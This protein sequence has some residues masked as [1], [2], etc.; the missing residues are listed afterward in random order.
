[1]KKLSIILTA[2]IFLTAC[3]AQEKQEDVFMQIASSQEYALYK[4]A[5]NANAGLIAQNQVDLNGIKLVLDAHLSVGGL[6]A[7]GKEPFSR[8]MGGVMWYENTLE[9]NKRIK[10]LDAKYKFLTFSREQIM[11]IAGLYDQITGAEDYKQLR[12]AAFQHIQNQ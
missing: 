11:E 10:A 6:E 2:L 5:F 4:K 7:I 12:D 1:M 9:Y 3:T 8:V